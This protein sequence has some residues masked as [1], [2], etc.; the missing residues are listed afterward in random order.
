METIDPRFNAIINIAFGGTHHIKSIKPYSGHG[1]TFLVYGTLSTWDDNRL[2]K[3]VIAA[4]HQ[5]VRVDIAPA[6]PGYIRIRMWKRIRKDNVYPIM[7]THPTLEEHLKLLK[8]N[9]EDEYQD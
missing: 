6:N 9:P 3:L 7:N 5:C 8:L 4:H 1:L 2:T